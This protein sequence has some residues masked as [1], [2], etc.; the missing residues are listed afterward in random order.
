ME[1]DKVCPED[2]SDAQ[3][4]YNLEVRTLRDS[5]E[6]LLGEIQVS[7][8]NGRDYITGPEIKKYKEKRKEMIEWDLAKEDIDYYD[9][10]FRGLPWHLVGMKE[11]KL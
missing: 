7:L 6:S 9:S 11:P 2:F 5:V 3:K 8:C 1:P 10:R 4:R